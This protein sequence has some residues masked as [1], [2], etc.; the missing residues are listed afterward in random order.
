MHTRSVEDLEGEVEVLV[1]PQTFQKVSRY[2]QPSTVV[3]DM[4]AVIMMDMD[5]D[6]IL[7]KVFKELS[8]KGI[9]VFLV[10]VGTANLGLMRRTGTLDAPNGAAIRPSSTQ[11][12]VS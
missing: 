1:F 6:R 9:Q 12:Q 4:S 10:N 7:V 3:I 11:P 2:I 5:G 8:S